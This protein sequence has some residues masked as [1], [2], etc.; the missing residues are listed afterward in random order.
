[1]EKSVHLNKNEHYISTL[2][3]GCTVSHHGK[4]NEDYR[5]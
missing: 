3:D 4:S 1:M 5:F 2:I